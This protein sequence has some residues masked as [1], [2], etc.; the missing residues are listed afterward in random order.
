MARTVNSR[1]VESSRAIRNHDM[2]EEAG[3][4]GG[5]SG[6][7]VGVLAVQGAFVEHERQ[8]EQLGARC[9]ELRQGSDVTRDFDALV[10][11]GGESTTQVKLLRELGMFDELKARIQAGM[12]TLG[13]CAGLI[14]LGHADDVE[15]FRTMPVKVQ[16]N[17]Y[18]RQLGSFHATDP[19]G[20]PLTFIRAPR[21]VGIG[22]G[23]EPG[24]NSG[25]E[26]LSSID[27]YPVAVRFGN[28]IA[29]AFHPELDDDPWIHRMLLSCVE[30]KAACASAR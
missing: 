29:C 14:L 25:V 12:P 9:I 2:P 6:I 10:L 21:I 11:P 5:P 7:T 3:G 1:T 26:V 16:R 23:N 15:G 22:S 24:A 28:Q 27:G 17:A 4:Q 20:R 8:L 19:A 30:K 13:T 18:G